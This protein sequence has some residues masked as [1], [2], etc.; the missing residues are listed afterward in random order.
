MTLSAPPKAPLRHTSLAVLAE[1]RA[2]RLS[3]ALLKRRCIYKEDSY[4]CVVSVLL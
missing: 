1:L 4:K 2:E 3:D